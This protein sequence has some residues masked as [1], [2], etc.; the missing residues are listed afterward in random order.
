MN[1][2]DLLKVPK[3]AAEKVIKG[4]YRKAA[5]ESH[6]DKND[7]NDER[8]HEVK[9]A[10]DVLSDPDRRERYDATGTTDEPK[11]NEVQ[12]RLIALFNSIIESESFTGNI[13]DGCKNNLQQ[14]IQMLNA[15]KEKLE[16]KCGTLE[17]QLGRV[18]AEGFNFY[19]QIISAKIADL[20]TNIEKI[21]HEL[22]VLKQVTELLDH[23]VDESPAIIT[24]GLQQG[25]F[26]QINPFAQQQSPFNRY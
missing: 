22:D 10:Y 9:L 15:Q 3:D 26:Q 16:G 23:Y 8:F 7:G 25:H 6:P 24:G 18:S 2:Y 12:D 1:L 21:N 11:K 20:K 17:K 13:I 19:D 14:A 4:A 5:Q